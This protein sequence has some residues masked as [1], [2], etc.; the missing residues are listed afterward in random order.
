M[1]ERLPEHPIDSQ[2]TQRWSPRA[3]TGESIDEATLLRFLEAARWAPSGFNAQPWRFIYGRTGTPAWAPIFNTLSAYNQGWA[4]RASAL[5]LVLSQTDWQAPGRDAPAP[6]IT[7]AFDAG[8]AW[9][10]LALQATLSGWHAHGIG[11][12]DRDAARLALGI[13]SGYDLH[14]VIAIGRRGD[15]AVLSEALQA[16]EAPNARLPLSQLA[17]EGRFLFAG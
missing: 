14:A 16:R 5:V 13:P 8:A 12:F 10:Y 11:G 6:N 1:S 2:F 7:H 4:Q 15:K 17:A 3:F 9:A